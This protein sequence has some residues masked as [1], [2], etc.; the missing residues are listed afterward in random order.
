MVVAMWIASAKEISRS[1]QAAGAKRTV[2]NRESQ[3]R[4]SCMVL[5][6]IHPVYLLDARDYNFYCKHLL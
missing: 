4:V 2:T 5:S 6:H 1:D 3:S